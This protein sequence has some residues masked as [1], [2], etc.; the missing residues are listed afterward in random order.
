MNK[1]IDLNPHERISIVMALR[2]RILAQWR[3]CFI[4][5]ERDG[6]GSP[7]ARRKEEI[8][9]TSVQAYRKV[10]PLGFDMWFATLKIR[11]RVGLGA[12]I[13]NDAVGGI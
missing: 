3:E 11:T 2:D 6:V 9:L 10:D 5:R 1:P 4:Y 7:D 8:I 13:E 12:I